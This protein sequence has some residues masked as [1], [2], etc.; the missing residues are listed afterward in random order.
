LKDKKGKKL[1]YL[2][3][4]NIHFIDNKQKQLEM[5]NQGKIDVLHGLPA[6]SIKEIVE[7]QISDF[8]NKPP[9][10]ILETSPEMATNYIE[11][12]CIKKPF[13]DKNVRLAIAYAINKNK[14]VES[15]L[16]GE[17][18]GPGNNGI[19]PPVFKDYDVS[20]IVGHAY[21][22]AKAKEYLKKAGYENGK[23]FP[24]VVLR[25]NSKSTENIRV[26]TE[27]QKELL[28]NL[29][30]N[31]ELEVS[32]L[33]QKIELNEHGNFD[34]SLSGWVVDMPSPENFLW[35]MYGENVPESLDESS[36]PNVSRYQNPE[37]DQLF[38]KILSESDED[39]KMEL[40]AK[41]EQM[42]INDAPVTPLWYNEKYRIVQ[43]YVQ[44]LNVNP[45]DLRDYSK[46]FMQKE[47]K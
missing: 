41:A 17:A 26:A 39:K 35:L 15:V 11:F 23:N 43:S 12:N 34:M 20:K 8:Q 30:I 18:F 25:T 47:V 45:M 40:I 16:N 28:T 27:I 32:S 10:Y 33:A 9:K 1:P 5:F 31:V 46:V 42:A 2:D 37:F 22:L 44:G 21:N 24:T 14:L 36:F 3:G 13:N 6:E 29:N 19:I 4:I 38:K 7:N